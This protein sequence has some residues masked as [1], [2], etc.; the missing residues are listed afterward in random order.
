MNCESSSLAKVNNGISKDERKVTQSGDCVEK[1]G[2]YGSN[3]CRRTVWDFSMDQWPAQVWNCCFW[4]EITHSLK[5]KL[6][7]FICWVEHCNLDVFSIH[8]GIHEL[9]RSDCRSSSTLGS[10]MLQS[11]IAFEDCSL[12]ISYCG[13]PG[14]QTKT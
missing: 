11:K 4:Y 8:M 6:T 14:K 5:V 1:C 10:S 9:I 13:L 2:H 7:V 12:C 3:P